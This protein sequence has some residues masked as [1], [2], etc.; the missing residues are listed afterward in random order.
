MTEE[1][2]NTTMELENN[3]LDNQPSCLLR[4]EA[5]GKEEHSY[6]E[7]ILDVLLD[8]LVFSFV[9]VL[10]FPVGAFIGAVVGFKFLCS[11]K[12]VSTVIQAC[13]RFLAVW[14]AVLVTTVLFVR[15]SIF[16]GSARELSQALPRAAVFVAIIWL[17]A[18][19]IRRNKMKYLLAKA[20]RRRRRSVAPEKSSVNSD[21]NEQRDDRGGLGKQ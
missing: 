20:E 3:G 13:F 18:F 4:Q 14:L 21:G 19:L 10:V 17:K 9:V 15:A 11:S 8:A 2:S 6:S 5:R 7:G 16:T 1:G 12:H